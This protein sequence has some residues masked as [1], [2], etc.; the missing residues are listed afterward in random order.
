MTAKVKLNQN[1]EVVDTAYQTTMSLSSVGNGVY[2]LILEKISR[3]TLPLLTQ[4]NVTQRKA[5]TKLQKQKKTARKRGIR[6]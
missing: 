2:V 5:G 4:Q 3:M 6:V 1:L